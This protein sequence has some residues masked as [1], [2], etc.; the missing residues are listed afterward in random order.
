MNKELNAILFFSWKNVQQQRYCFYN[1]SFVS[2]DYVATD[3]SIFITEVAALFS[4]LSI[5][6]QECFA[7]FGQMHI[8]EAHVHSVQ[9]KKRLKTEKWIPQQFT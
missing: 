8:P 4:P 7:S 6:F 9:A 5:F 3:F 1:F 2:I